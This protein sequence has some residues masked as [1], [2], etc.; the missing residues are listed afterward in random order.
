MA[1]EQVIAPVKVSESTAAH[2]LKVR[3][4]T[5]CSSKMTPEISLFSLNFSLFLI[6]LMV[7]KSW[8]W[9]GPDSCS[10]ARSYK[11]QFIVPSQV[12]CPLPPGAPLLPSLGHNQHSSANKVRLSRSIFQ[13]IHFFHQGTGCLTAYVSDAPSGVHQQGSI[14]VYVCVSLDFCCVYFRF[15]VVHTLDSSCVYFRF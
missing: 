13:G 1:S 11:H 7:M 10:A 5:R 14:G 9:V 2:V 6:T 3:N 15:L 8:A 4:V 12:R